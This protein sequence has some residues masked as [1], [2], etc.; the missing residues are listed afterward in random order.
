MPLKR[1]EQQEVLTKYFRM[2]EQ[3]GFPVIYGATHL[4]QLLDIDPSSLGGMINIP[5]NYYYRFCIPKRSGGSRN[6]SAPNAVISYVQHWILVNILNKIEIG[7]YATGFRKGYSIK[8]NAL[9]HVGNAEV[10]KMDLKDFFPSI[11]I[12]R[13]WA[14]FR[15]CGYTKR[16][17]YYLA[18]LCCFNGCLPQGACTSPVLSNI[19][20]KRL[21]ARLGGLSRC[22]SLQY[23]RYADDLTFSGNQ[24]PLRFVEYV[25]EIVSSEGFTVNEI[26]TRRLGPAS[27]KIITGVS[28]SSGK[29]KLPREYKRKVRQEVFYILKYGIT[30]HQRRINEPFDPIKVER[31]IGKLTFW[32][33]IEP[34]NSF[35]LQNIK[36][37]KKYS[38]ALDRV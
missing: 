10:V 11:T 23:T 12:N 31:L 18:A 36:K 1:Q 8:L 24:I 13:V 6:I 2:L 9:A 16:V 19:I 20:A 38:I 35:V 17:S 4:S 15:N 5:Q 34:E 14:V 28:V 21:D 30:D 37:L 33:S 22:F 27:Q 26:K 7:K 32:K 3:R 25:K 29:I